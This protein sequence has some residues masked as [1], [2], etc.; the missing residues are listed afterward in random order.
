MSRYE[1]SGT[2]AQILTRLYRGDSFAS[3]REELGCGNGRI[4]RLANER[5]IPVK[6]PVLRRIGGAK[7]IT[8]T[9]N[10][11]PEGSTLPRLHLSLLVGW[12]TV[13]IDYPDDDDGVITIRKVTT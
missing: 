3:I 6:G 10:R 12:E 4:R 7:T 5:N 13:Q 1:V 11:P 9:S 8:R 2:D